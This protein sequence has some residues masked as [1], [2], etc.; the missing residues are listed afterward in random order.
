MY[1][2]LIYLIAFLNCSSSSS[3]QVLSPL[4]NLVRSLH[5]QRYQGSLEQINALL[6]CA[7][8]LPSFFDEPNSDAIFYDYDV[9]I[10]K[11]ILDIYFHCVN[12]M[13]ETVSSFST[14]QEPMIRSKVLSFAIFIVF[15]VV[16][17]MHCCFFISPTFEKLGAA[18]SKR[19]NCH[20]REIALITGQSA[21]W[22][23]AATSSIRNFEYSAF[24]SKARRLV[25]FSF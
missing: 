22:L 24:N 2:K 25:L 12:W 8:V 18:P 16:T 3:I 14:Q 4:F 1:I 6:G 5:L 9:E 19:A 10:Q 20:R 17:I 15:Y 13:R 23:F 21:N 7:I 11:R